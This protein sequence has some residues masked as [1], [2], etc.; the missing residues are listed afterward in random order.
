MRLRRRL[1]LALVRAFPSRPDVRGV[2]Y[3]RSDMDRARRGLV[4]AL[5]GTHGFD[6]EVIGGGVRVTARAIRK[7]AARAA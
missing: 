4:D 3:P 1:L 7:R 6:V 2:L 5:A